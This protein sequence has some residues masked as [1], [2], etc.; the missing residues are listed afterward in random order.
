MKNLILLIQFCAIIGSS[1]LAQQ[2]EIKTIPVDYSSSGKA[3][4]MFIAGDTIKIECDT[5]FIMNK[6]RYQFYKNIHSAI[7]NDN[8]STCKNLLKAYEIRLSDHEQ[9]YIQLVE[10]SRNAEKVALE[11]AAFTQHSLAETQKTLVNTQNSLQE[12]IKNLEI[13]NDHLKKER[14]N[15]AGKKVLI[16]IG[17][18]A[19]G[20]ITGVLVAK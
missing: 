1:V 2:S 18:V 12:T 13:A 6:G 19:V 3:P 5:V 10:K 17:G 20:I 16:G 8:D 11:L 14:W 9:S 4:I 15:S 7:Q